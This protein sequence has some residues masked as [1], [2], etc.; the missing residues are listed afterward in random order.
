MPLLHVKMIAVL[1]IFATLWLNVNSFRPLSN[2]ADDISLET[3]AEDPNVTLRKK[4]V[5]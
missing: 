3:P 5:G 4:M 1:L 2:M